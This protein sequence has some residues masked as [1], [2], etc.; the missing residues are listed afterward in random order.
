MAKKKN[1]SRKLPKQLG[2]NKSAILIYAT[3][4]DQHG[5][6]EIS[7]TVYRSLSELQTNLTNINGSKKGWKFPHKGMI[8]FNGTAYDATPYGIAQAKVDA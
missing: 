2:E 5:R 7:G 6:V 4:T 8:V 3:G 1:E